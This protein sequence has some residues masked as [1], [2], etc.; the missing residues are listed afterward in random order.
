MTTRTEGWTQRLAGLGGATV[1]GAVM[2]AGVP[3]LLGDVPTTNHWLVALLTT[4]C[5]W[6]LSH[7]SATKGDLFDP[8][9]AVGGVMFVYFPLRALYLLHCEHPLSHVPRYL[10]VDFDEVLPPALLL[11]AAA[12]VAAMA[13]YLVPTG[14]LVARLMPLAPALKLDVPQGRIRL[15]FLLGLF[16]KVISAASGTHL[17][18]TSQ[19]VNRETQAWVELLTSCGTMSL[20]LMGTEYFRGRLSQRDAL[21]FFAAVLVDV[22]W[23]LATG[24][25]LRLLMA[26]MMV[27]LARHYS[28]TPVRLVHLAALAASFA[29][30][31]VPVVQQFRNVFGE[32]LGAGGFEVGSS[33]TAI[34]DAA[35]EAG[36][37]DDFAAGALTS[38]IDRF[39]GIDSV[40]LAMKMTPALLPHGD[41]R[42]Y[43]LFPVMALV[44]RIAWKTKPVNIDVPNWETDYWGQSAEEETSVARSLFGALYIAFGAAWTVVWS[45]GLGLVWR[46]TREYVRRSWGMCSAMLYV[47]QL[48]AMLRIENDLPLIYAAYVRN[49]LVIVALFTLLTRGAAAPGA[50]NAQASAAR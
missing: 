33:A 21:F 36:Q 9:P 12:W 49:F 35:S 45:F 27:L 1:A 25:K 19:G 23:A 46:T 50:G 42:L 8:L 40:A 18:F 10:G 44:P 38:T 47:V 20:F 29:F 41:T 11:V 5:L 39:H 15:L 2:G 17:A 31:V 32:R 6:P 7:A 14:R 28:R 48:A 34:V 16:G 4:L 30:I 37:A 13:G 24:G 22:F 26:V 43:L 3:L